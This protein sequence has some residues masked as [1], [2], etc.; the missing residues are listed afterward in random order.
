M[1]KNTRNF[2][3]NN[4]SC[5]WPL[6]TPAP[7]LLLVPPRPLL[8]VQ[9]ASKCWWEKKKWFFFR[10]CEIQHEWLV[11]SNSTIFASILG[12]FITTTINYWFIW[13]INNRK[14][15]TNLTITYI[16][17]VPQT[18]PSLSRLFFVTYPLK[19]HK[20]RLGHCESGPLET[21]RDKTVNW[22]CWIPN[23]EAKDYL[24]SLPPINHHCISHTSSCLLQVSKLFY[25]RI[26]IWCIDL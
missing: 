10:T 21:F 5:S 19:P 7:K 15:E 14:L 22:G 24:P 20:I 13:L 11:P 12:A 18:T 4:V 25:C 16:K 23:S 17:F 6:Q 26:C 3:L 9:S 1:S 8:Q 2:L